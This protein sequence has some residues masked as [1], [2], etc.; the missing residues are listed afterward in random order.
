M[1]LLQWIVKNSG[2]GVLQKRYSGHFCKI[3]KKTPVVESNTY[4]VEHLG[5]VASEMLH[6]KFLENYS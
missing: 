2:P 4:F 3:H 1:R 5:T 6:D